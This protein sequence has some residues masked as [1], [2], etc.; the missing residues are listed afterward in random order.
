MLLVR[1]VQVLQTVERERHP[2][3]RSR[4][5]TCRETRLQTTG[6]LV[7]PPVCLSGLCTSTCDV[8][9]EDEDGVEGV[10]AVQRRQQRRVVVEAQAVAVPVH[11]H[12]AAASV[13]PSLLTWSH[14]RV[15]EQNRTRDRFQVS[16]LALQL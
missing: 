6:L 4:T 15:W 13:T 2:R 10:G 9:V 16:R 5:C 7:C 14:R 12:H 11:T 3:V 1:L 8:A